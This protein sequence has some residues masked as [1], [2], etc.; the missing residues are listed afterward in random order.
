MN[1]LITLPTQNITQLNYFNEKAFSNRIL[2][3]S[4]SVGQDHVIL[5]E[6]PL[7]R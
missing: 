6:Q 1:K 5:D 4:S 7:N 3:W 2:R